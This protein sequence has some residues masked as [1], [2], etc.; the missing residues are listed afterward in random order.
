MMMS[1][2]STVDP[3]GRIRPVQ[4]CGY[5]ARGSAKNGHTLH[6]LVL[7]RRP[8]TL[9]ANVANNIKCGNDKLEIGLCVAVL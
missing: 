7:Q 6:V 1:H 5:V 9:C 2:V 4:K 3:R 8:K